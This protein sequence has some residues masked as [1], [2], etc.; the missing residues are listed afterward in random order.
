[1]LP[2]Q[3]SNV[4]NLR[5]HW[6]SVRAWVNCRREFVIPCQVLQSRCNALFF[7]SRKGAKGELVY[8]VLREFSF[9]ALLLICPCLKSRIFLS[10]L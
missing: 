10:I 1:M 5:S 7:V 3:H 6:S 4:M 8:T 2:K 9:V